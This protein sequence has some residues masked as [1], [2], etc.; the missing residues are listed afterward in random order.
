MLQQ[1]LILRSRDVDLGTLRL[2]LIHVMEPDGMGSRLRPRHVVTQI[3]TRR[4]LPHP[5]APSPEP[6]GDSVFTPAGQH[7]ERPNDPGEY[8]VA[9]CWFTDRE[10]GECDGEPRSLVEI[11]DVA[12]QQ[13]SRALV[14][15]AGELL[16]P[17]FA[18]TTRAEALALEAVA[19]VCSKLSGTPAAPI[20]A[21]GPRTQRYLSVVRDYAETV[22][23]ERPTVAAVSAACGI[24]GAHLM[25]LFTRA[26]GQPLHD[27]IEGVRLRRAMTE[28][29]DS[30]RQL[31]EISWMLGF[32]SPSGFSIAFRRATG[33][34]PQTFRQQ[35]RR[36]SQY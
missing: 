19:R 4:P 7:E 15:M 23:G 30:R 2:S 24:S 18:G 36:W 12:D 27:Y 22:T 28:L 17:G 33:Q 31:K 3:L 16:E 14:A 29:A 8:R 10:V 9:C 13:V 34:S 6:V 5:A 11:N 20:R 1:R 32:A 26:T 25:R 21:P 35:H